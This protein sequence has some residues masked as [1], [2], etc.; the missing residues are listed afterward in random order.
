MVV[1][2]GGLQSLAALTRLDVGFNKCSVVGAHA[3]IASLEAAGR[4]REN[5]S[6]LRHLDMSG[7]ELSASDLVRLKK[8]LSA[9][10]ELRDLCI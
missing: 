6:G 1:V 3:I 10:H 9:L 8:H 5:G 7:S 4:L 2:A